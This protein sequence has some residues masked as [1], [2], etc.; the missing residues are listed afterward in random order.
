M[1]YLIIAAIIGIIISVL[2]LFF[3]DFESESAGFI[4]L[5]AS[6]I[7]LAVCAMIIDN[8]R[9]Q[10]RCQ[11]ILDMARTNSDSVNVLVNCGKRETTFIIQPATVPA[12]RP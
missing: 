12:E 11:Q 5:V 4:L 7:L 2:M 9:T 10:E 3:G 1:T 6:I 8:R